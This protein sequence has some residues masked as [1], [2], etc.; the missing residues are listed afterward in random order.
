MKK[1]KKKKKTPNNQVGEKADNK[2]AGSIV[3]RVLCAVTTEDLF[4]GNSDNRTIMLKTSREHL[5]ALTKF[6][7]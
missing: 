2:A 3:S 4:T 6:P 1:K 7:H 5:I